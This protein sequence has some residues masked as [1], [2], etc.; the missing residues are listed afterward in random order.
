MQAHLT[1]AALAA[2]C[3]YAQADQLAITTSK[4]NTLYESP[5]G[6]L[7]NGAG[8]GFFV[9]RVGFAGGGLIRRGLIAFDLSA[10][11]YGST[12]TAVSLQLN[13][14]ATNAGN[15]TTTLHRALANW[16]EGPS[17]APP[18]GGAGTAPAPGDATWKHTFFPGSTWSTPGG[19][20]NATPTDSILMGATGTYVLPTSSGLVS[21]VQFWLN[22]PGQNFGWV[23]KG[24][25][26][27]MSTSKRLDTKEN[28]IPGHQ[29]LLTIT[30]TSSTFSYC[31][32][33]VNSLS[34][35]PTIAG[36]GV[37]SATAGSGFTISASNV[38]NNKPGLLIYSNTGAAAVPFVGGL[39][40]MNAPVR[41]SSGLNSG[42]N[43]P[44][45]DCS[46]VYSIDMNSFAV[47]GLGGIPAVYLGVPGTVVYSQ[48]WGRDNGFT[49]PNNATLSNALQ[50][51]V[52]P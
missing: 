19:V 44:P 12:I 23:L 22:N 15:E 25:E 42:G 35:T 51:T 11:P 29:P 48:F 20:F 39:R 18:G 21:D 34:C 24:N 40:C 8:D 47:G 9:G 7:S 38:I 17:V 33:K 31:T 32:A 49:P 4:D 52:G 36:A 3:A 50:F 5:N 30:Y 43:P 28:T 16:G 26:A 37:S 46:G 41:R 27:Q 1:I 14:S 10:I 2:F 45:N 6:S 13:C